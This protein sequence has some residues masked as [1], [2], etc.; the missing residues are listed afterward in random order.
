M[1]YFIWTQSPVFLLH[2]VQRPRLPRKKVIL[3]FRGNVRNFLMSRHM[4]WL[5]GLKD[6]PGSS[7]QPVQ[8][9]CRP[10]WPPL[11]VGQQ[12]YRTRQLPLLLR[13]HPIYHP[14]HFSESRCYNILHQARLDQWC[15]GRATRLYELK[16][17]E[18]DFTSIYASSHNHFWLL[19]IVSHLLS[20]RLDFCAKCL[21][22]KT[23]TQGWPLVKEA[24]CQ[25]T[26]PDT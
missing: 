14:V 18:A 21:W 20:L 6:S 11:S 7:L 16:S 9:L 23:C 26:G 12:L 25:T 8:Q 19:I 4:S 2:I 3:W 15:D 22:L 13:L 1:Q 17:G 5:L 10:V 24:A